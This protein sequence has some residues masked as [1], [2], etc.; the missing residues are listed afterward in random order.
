M[1][2]PGL[3]RLPGGPRDPIFTLEDPTG[4][5]NHYT[6]DTIDA[7]VPVPRVYVAPSASSYSAQPDR[8]T[9][10]FYLRDVMAHPTVQA[11]DTVLILTDTR[12]LTEQS[13]WRHT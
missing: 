11:A 3:I 6:T 12:P 2:V 1:A 13:H 5:A 10:A 8:L 9:L 7:T 4:C